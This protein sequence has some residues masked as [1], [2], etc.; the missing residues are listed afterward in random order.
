[1]GTLFQTSFK[2]GR[3]NN[4][5]DDEPL[6]QMLSSV[7]SSSV[8]AQAKSMKVQG[9]QA[10]VLT[11]HNEFLDEAEKIMSGAH[12]LSRS[13]ADVQTTLL[14]ERDKLTAEMRGDPSTGRSPQS[15]I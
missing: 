14:G 12:S 6:E 2:D 3:Y 8:I 1:V 10:L 11:S 13:I 5:R 7:L 4:W 15:S 9:L